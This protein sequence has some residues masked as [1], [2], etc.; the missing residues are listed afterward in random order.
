MEL[1]ICVDILFFLLLAISTPSYALYK[2]QGANGGIE[3][4]E[5]PC[6]K[7]ADVTPKDIKE[8]TNKP[9]AYVGEKI[10]L[11]LDGIDI[12]AVLQVIADFSGIVIKVDPGIQGVV[13]VHYSGPRDQILDQIANR[14]GLVISVEGDAIRVK[15]RQ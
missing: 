12:R 7:G 2:C 14:N 3:Y 15:K 1:T 11:N 4:R 8:I 9:K 13:A 6:V 5:G 10:T